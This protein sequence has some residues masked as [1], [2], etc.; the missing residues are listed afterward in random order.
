MS[1]KPIPNDSELIPRLLAG[2]EAAYRQAVNAYHGIM[3]QVA[4]AIIGDSVA[5]EVV[6]ESWLAIL[7]GLPRFERRSSLKTWML[8]IVGNTAKSR[9]RHDSRSSTFSELSSTDDNSVD[10]SYFDK[11][12]HWD[13][14]LPGWQHETPESLLASAQMVACLNKGIAQLPA[15]QKAVLTLRDIQCLD[16]DIICKILDITESNARVLLHRARSQIR[17]ALDQLE[18]NR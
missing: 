1:D 13:S 8:R 16:M 10:P 17:N 7:K 6:Q 12:G 2:E 9:L 11:Q 15:L 14:P 18:R 4:R 3:V 5:E